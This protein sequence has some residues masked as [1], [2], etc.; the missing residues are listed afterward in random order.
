MAGES[1]TSMRFEV[2]QQDGKWLV[3]DTV[4]GCAAMK[5]LASPLKLTA[6][7]YARHPQNPGVLVLR[8]DS[9]TSLINEATPTMF[10]TQKEAQLSAD[11][12]NDLFNS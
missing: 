2:R 3:W 4:N 9:V 11:T 5:G 7:N 1:G 6:D 8:P 10:W 12:L